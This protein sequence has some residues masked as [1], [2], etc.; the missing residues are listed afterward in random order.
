MIKKL[1]VVITSIVVS[2]NLVYVQPVKAFFFI[3]AL[4]N[5]ATM[6]FLGNAVVGSAA[7]VMGIANIDDTKKHLTNLYND[8]KPLIDELSKKATFAID[9]ATDK[10]IPM[11]LDGGKDI[12]T[13]LY[14][15]VRDTVL[16]IYD[17][18]LAKDNDD[19]VGSLSPTLTY[20]SSQ[21][22]RQSVRAPDGF[23]F[24]I[25]SKSEKGV[26]ALANAF[27][28]EQPRGGR[29]VFDFNDVYDNGL[30]VNSFDY[31]K[32][33]PDLGLDYDDVYNLIVGANTFS[34]MV[35]VAKLL[36]DNFNISIVTSDYLDKYNQLLFAALDSYF[37]SI[38]A[39][40]P[41]YLPIP[42]AKSIEKVNDIPAG[43][44]LV[45]NPVSQS[46]E[47]S[48]G[49]VWQGTDAQLDVAIPNVKVLTNADGTVVTDANGIPRTVATTD[50]ATWIDTK[51]GETVTTGTGEGSIPID[52]DVTKV[53]WGKLQEIPIT[54]TEKFPFSLPWD[55]LHAV[56][57]LNVTPE[58][59]K[60][61]ENFKVGNINIPIDIELPE[62]IDKYTPFIRFG[63][64]M[65]FTIGLIYA[66][67]SLM[68]GG[69]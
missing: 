27:Y 35:S 12:L 6:A 19:T 13:K 33:Y 10:Y 49:K 8:S 48:Q 4:A 9:Q 66:T 2:F 55:I 31:I 14:D 57:E 64:V 51:T 25:T 24:K 56:K 60:I 32:D 11:V 43:T 29:I 42:R 18:Y 3:P 1:I 5:P 67:R 16:N 50:G 26:F 58:K 22:P 38:D 46:W 62:W 45:F 36:D 15:G 39:N 20:D 54:F 21:Y 63:F 53:N 52:G 34:K 17:E 28:I 23:L 44:D 61:K 7:L 40:A 69:V 59:F 41:F 47:T 68:G 37:P 30:W 65:V